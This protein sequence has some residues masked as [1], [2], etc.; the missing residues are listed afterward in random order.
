MDNRE[1][2]AWLDSRPATS[3]AQGRFTCGT[4]LGEWRTV[5]Y[6]GKGCSSEVYRVVNTRTGREGALKLLVS[7][8]PDIRDRFLVEMDSMR[9]LQQGAFPTFYGSGVCGG[10]PYYVMEYLKPILFPPPRKEIAGFMVA[11]AK[12]VQR[13]HTAGYVHRDLKP[14]N[15]LCRPNGQ[16]VLIDP[17][18][19]KKMEKTTSQAYPSTRSMVNGRPVGVGT[20]GFAA[21][22]QLIEGIASPRSDVFSLGKLLEACFNGVSIQEYWRVII[23]RATQASPKDRYASAEDFARAIRRRHYAGYFRLFVSVGIVALVVG[24]FMGWHRSK[25]VRSIPPSKIVV[26]IPTKPDSLLKN[27]GESDDEHLKRLLPLATQGN[28]VAQLLVAEA[29]Y[30]GRGTKEDRVEAVKWYRSAA[31]SKNHDAEASLG[32][33][34]LHGYG[35]ERNDQLAVSYFLDA[36]EGS[37]VVAMTNLAFC[38]INGRGVVEEPEEGFKWARRAADQ[39]H[40]PGQVM[41]AEC[42]L[43]GKGVERNPKEA[44]VWLKAAARQGNKRAKRLLEGLLEVS[45]PDQPPMP[46][47]SPSADP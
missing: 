7:D 25:T 16:P 27:P 31:K 13:L 10:I 17:G 32:L 29:F 46:E 26:E 35:C 5:A 34:Y 22:E 47:Q 36:V 39:G 3:P 44:E 37:N 43:L 12:A 11:V 41:L 20:M 15:I 2:N 21:P 38:Y 33:C 6:L 30:Y 45:S 18:L 8:N 28:V 9:F 1:L 14:A 40:A 23:R 19:V 4:I 24:Q 42:L